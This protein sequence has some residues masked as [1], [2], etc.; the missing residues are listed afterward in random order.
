MKT[1]I[2]SLKF[3]GLPIIALTLILSS[4]EKVDELLLSDS[5]IL[6]KD[7]KGKYTLVSVRHEDYYSVNGGVDWILQYDTTYSASGSFDLANI[8]LAE[9][10]GTL[11]IQYE[12]FNESHA[13]NGSAFSDDY[14]RLWVI[15]NQQ[16]DISCLILFNPPAN[17]L[18]GAIEERSGDHFIL[19][20]GE[21][22][23]DS[24][25]RKY[26]YFRFEKAR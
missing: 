14:E 26:R 7:L 2:N 11:T 13:V 19:M 22:S 5:E 12:G 16:E 10:T 23:W 4:C 25:S 6:M 8:D 20:F 3:T 24:S 1:L 15:T 9:Y 18:Q 21:E 17:Y